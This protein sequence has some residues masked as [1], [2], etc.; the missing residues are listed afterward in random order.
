MDGRL[1]ARFLP[2][3]VVFTVPQVGTRTNHRASSKHDRPQH[4]DVGKPP[5]ETH[6]AQGRPQVGVSACI[7]AYGRFDIGSRVNGQ[8]Q[9]QPTSLDWTFHSG[10]PKHL[11]ASRDSSFSCSL[12]INVDSH[13][14]QNTSFPSLWDRPLG[15][16]FGRA[17][18]SFSPHRHKP[19]HWETAWAGT[20]LEPWLCDASSSPAGPCFT[21]QL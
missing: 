6:R 8:L 1:Y 7:A 17:L 15:G 16:L 21:L 13:M 2:D 12:K 11:C 9:G 10:A 18:M 4:R 14:S 3:A 20:A 5:R 19:A